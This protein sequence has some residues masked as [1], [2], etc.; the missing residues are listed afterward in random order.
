M[1]NFKNDYCGIAHE[2]VLEKLLDNKKNTYVGYGMDEVSN[3]AKKLIKKVFDCNKSDIHF[4]SGGTITNKVLIAH[5]LKPYEAV[6]SAVSGHINVHETG[7]IE[8]TGHKVIPVNHYLGKIKPFDIYQA[9]ISHTDEHMVK[10][11]MV[12]ISNSTE[13]GTVYTLNELIDIYK[14]CQDL[15]L[16]LYLDGARL[17][18]ALTSNQNDIK[19]TDLV[20]YTDAFYIGGTKNGLLF[21]EAL[22]INNNNLKEE[23]RYSVK[24]FG[25]MVAKG[26]ICG[27]EFEALFEDGLFFEL[28]KKENELSNYL[29]NELN[30]LNIKLYLPQETNQIFIVLDKSLYNKLKDEVLFEV[31][32][33]QENNIV[34]RLVVHY[35]HQKA[36]I[37]NLISYISSLLK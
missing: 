22:V 24:H 5:T 2:K 16:Y 25:G 18:A 10:P 12:Y 27:L 26:F 36:D 30:K 15:G 4:L 17:G 1:L 13:Y 14:M 35:L 9:F 33:E 29:A 11:K 6:I 32:E 7:A 20:K 8:E 34:I 37:D 21:G 31:W 28:A 23:F 3:N 19:P